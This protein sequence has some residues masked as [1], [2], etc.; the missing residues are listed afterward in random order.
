MMNITLIGCGWL[1]FPLAKELFSLGHE[2]S[3]STRDNSKSEEL[4]KLGIKAFIFDEKDSIDPIIA[5]NTDIL[6]ITVPPGK[7]EDYP[8]FIESLIKQFPGNTRIIF[9]SSISVYQEE[10][11]II[12]ESS[13]VNF[14][15]RI[16]QA[17]SLIK[18]YTDQYIILRL[19]GLIGENRH[20]INHM[21]NKEVKN[22]N[23][24][25]NLVH[26]GDVINVIVNLIQKNQWKLLYNICYP[27][28]P[29]KKVYYTQIALDR[30]MG[31]LHFENNDLSGKIIDG[32]LIEK[33]TNFSY[34]FNLTG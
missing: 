20:P 17:E 14:E 27:F 28:H 4:N 12:T 9:T 7:T 33:T 18:D 5:K 19:A 1:G 21:L 31:S 6:I 10:P 2:V 11:T 32:S 23:F 34:A 8:G 25:I 3:G 16:F 24:P 15:N 22:P 30:S 26:Q 29:S 13:K